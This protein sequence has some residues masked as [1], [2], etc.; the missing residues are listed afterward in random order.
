MLFVYLLTIIGLCVL[1]ADTLF[2]PVC[3]GLKAN[4]CSLHRLGVL[5]NLATEIIDA[6]NVHAK[7]SSFERSAH[8]ALLSPC[9]VLCCVE[10]AKALCVAYC[11]ACVVL[12]V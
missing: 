8:V 3:C 7:D 4:V 10:C 2:H 5:T 12:I 6:A 11:L 1:F 9:C